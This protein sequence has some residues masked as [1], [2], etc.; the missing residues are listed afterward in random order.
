MMLENL[1]YTFTIFYTI[2]FLIFL[3][4][5]LKAAK[6]YNNIVHY[7]S[8]SIIVA[9]RNEEENILKCLI[10]L[11]QLD[12]PKEKLDIII[13]NDQSTD[14]TKEI[15]ENFI[16]DKSHFKLLNSI[17]STSQHL[18]GK[19]NAVAQGI[20][21]STGEFLLFTDA[22]CTV[23]KD[24]VKE[25]VANFK[26][27]IG[28]VGGYTI[29]KA[30]S[31]FEGIQTLDWIYL[32]NIAASSAT[33]GFPLT[34][35]GNNLAIRKKCYDEVGGYYNIRFSVTEDYALTRA[36]LNKTKYKMAFPLNK[37]SIVN[38]LPCKNFTELYHQKKRWGVGGLDMIPLGFL[39]FSIP[40]IF[41]MLIMIG[42]YYLNICVLIV[43][44]IIKIFMDFMLL[45]YS[46]KQLK[47]LRYIKYFL[48]FEIY[49]FI[50][51]II[52]PIIVVINKKVLWKERQL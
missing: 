30:N 26:Q 47:Y 5:L 8:V 42:L 12:Y 28:I 18:R 48:F 50:Y 25:I 29:L 36:I 49:L 6:P 32:F 31:I 3:F 46:L 43:P 44:I 34:G 39:V 51:V 22:D 15:V 1:I 21:N 11:S 38:S 37:K 24:W 40:F 10:S 14:H 20:E 33:L 9:A 2:E 45:F 13:V 27:N 17:K 23:P 7:P 41:N 4:G 52:L 19:A 35:I 16:K